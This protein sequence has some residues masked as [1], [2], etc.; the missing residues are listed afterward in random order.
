MLTHRDRLAPPNR[1]LVSAICTS[2]VIDVHK[3]GY[4]EELVD[5]LHYVRDEGKKKLEEIKRQKEEEMQKAREEKEKN[6]SRLVE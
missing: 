3:D 1:P 2:I 6:R 5:Y 4:W